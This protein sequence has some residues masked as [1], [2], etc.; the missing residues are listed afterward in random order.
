MPSPLTPASLLPT[1]IPAC[2]A[3]HRSSQLLDSDAY[4]Q[5]IN[6]WVHNAP[7]TLLTIRQSGQAGGG[8]A[9]GGGTGGGRASGGGGLDHGPA[10]PPELQRWVFDWSELTVLGLLGRGSYGRVRCGWLQCKCKVLPCFICMVLLR[11]GTR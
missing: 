1:L 8:G 11:T 10:I 9:S 3:H 6:T 7:A 2:P 4:L 5:G